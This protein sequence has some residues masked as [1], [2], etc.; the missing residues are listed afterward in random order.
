[1]R[2]LTP[3]EIRAKEYQTPL[4]ARMRATVNGQAS[5]AEPR[6]NRDCT[7]CDHYQDYKGGKSRKGT[8]RLFFNRTG[9]T[10]AFDGAKAKACMDW[11]EPK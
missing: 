3:N 7:N 6:L 5:W 2:A 10:I 1:M 9:R 4:E 11:E 8:C